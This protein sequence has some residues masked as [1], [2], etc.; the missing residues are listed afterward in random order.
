VD[1]NE[2]REFE[3]SEY[4]NDD[5][6]LWGL[7]YQLSKEFLDSLRTPN[8]GYTSTVL[9]LLGVDWPP[10]KGWKQRIIGKFIS[11]ENYEELNRIKEKRKIIP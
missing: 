6:N 1:E 11:A 7:N 10:I 3:D 2:L 4:F 5:F 8:G 9:K